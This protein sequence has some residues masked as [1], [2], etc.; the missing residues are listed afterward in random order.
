MATPGSL[1]LA[2]PPSLASAIEPLIT[3]TDL[4]RLLVCDR[5]TIERLRAAGKLPPPDLKIGR[6]PRWKR[7][8]IELWIERGGRP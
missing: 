7:S 1:R 6:L 3:V 8:T 5:R 2:D 4:A